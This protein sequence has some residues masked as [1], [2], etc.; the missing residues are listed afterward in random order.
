M[1]SI[2]SGLR[3]RGGCPAALPSGRVQHGG[4]VVASWVL[5]GTPA[6]RDDL[7]TSCVRVQNFPAVTAACF[8][9]KKAVYEAVGGL[10]KRTPTQGFGVTT[11]CFRPGVRLAAA[12]TLYAEFCITKPPAV[13]AMT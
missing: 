6:A 4:A 1:L 2:P 7:G 13:G 9:T 12:P 10:T 11:S 8:T 5:P 3:W